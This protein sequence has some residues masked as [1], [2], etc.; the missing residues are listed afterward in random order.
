MS[1]KDFSETVKDYLSDDLIK[2]HDFG[3]DFMNDFLAQDIQEFVEKSLSDEK[4]MTKQTKNLLKLFYF[5]TKIHDA[6]VSDCHEG[7]CE[8]LSLYRGIA[9]Q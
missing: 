4:E 8:E 7:F 3:D 2:N 6:V 5:F 1:L 9:D